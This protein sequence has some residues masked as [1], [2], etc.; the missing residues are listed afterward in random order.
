MKEDKVFLFTATPLNF[1]H[2]EAAAPNTVPA[3]VINTDTLTG[4]VD[5]ETLEDISTRYSSA[6]NQA[7]ATIP[8]LNAQS[9]RVIDPNFV[10]DIKTLLQQ[11]EQQQY[12][13]QQL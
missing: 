11:V 9:Y 1:D 7:S 4:V 10:L 13:Q 8:S 3:E 2:S 6:K 12:V 5:V